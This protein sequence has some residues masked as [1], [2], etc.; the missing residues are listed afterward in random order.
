M[1]N[2]TKPLAKELGAEDIALLIAPR[3]LSIV[4]GANDAFFT[5]SAR[6]LR[7]ET[8][9]RFHSVGAGSSF[10][11]KVIPDIGHGIDADTVVDLVEQLSGTPSKE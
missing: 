3:P 7:D 5:D 11:T 9:R 8:E 2:T 4:W 10:S 6:A 1:P